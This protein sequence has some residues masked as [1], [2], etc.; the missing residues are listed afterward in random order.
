MVTMT[1]TSAMTNVKFGVPLLLGVI[2][3][4]VAAFIVQQ[5]QQQQKQPF[6]S[7]S[8]STSRRLLLPQTGLHAKTTTKLGETD[9]PQN[10]KKIHL[11]VLVHGWL[12][13]PNELGYLQEELQRQSSSSSSS[14]PDSSSTAMTVVHAAEC[15]DGRTSDGIVPGGKR[16]AVEINSLVEQLSIEYNSY[17]HQ[18]YQPP[19]PKQQQ[20][21]Q[22]NDSKVSTYSQ[23]RSSN[24]VS[25]RGSDGYKLDITISLVGNSLGGLYARY[26]VKDIAWGLQQQRQQQNPSLSSMAVVV[27]PGQFVTTC[28]P[29]LGVNKHTY[30]RIP[31]FAEEIIGRVL[32]QTGKD[33]FQIVDQVDS[34]TKTTS[35]SSTTT[36][37]SSIIHD[38]TTKD[39][40]LTPLSNF[41]RRVA[42]ANAY[43][44]DFQVPTSTA[45]FW[46][47]NDST[48]ADADASSP[49]SLHY[50]VSID[51][52]NYHDTS[53]SEFIPFNPLQPQVQGPQ[54]PSEVVMILRT[55]PSASSSSSSSSKS[56]SENTA[57]L[58]EKLNSLGWTKIVCDV[59]RHIVT[60][61][62]RSLPFFAKTPK[63]KTEQSS[64]DPRT[65]TAKELLSLFDT[66]YGKNIP[67]GHTIAVANSKDTLNR[68]ITKGGR[69]IMD[70]LAKDI[71]TFFD[72]TEQQQLSQQK[73]HQMKDGQAQP[74]FVTFNGN[75]NSKKIKG[76]NSFRQD[77]VLMAKR[78]DN[79]EDQEEESTNVFGRVLA[80]FTNSPGGMILFPFVV[81]FGLDILLNTF[82][83]TKRTFEFF[84]LGQ[85]PSTDTWF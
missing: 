77:T 69:P 40:Y 29:H 41:Q 15:N 13:S 52:Q 51:N 82:F 71:L 58:S 27:K 53:A 67:L 65:F 26:A 85:A 48:N 42:F 34:T 70:Y 2:I 33:L 75:V 57:R 63:T 46:E 31:R 36:S 10:Q 80:P 39:E 74:G 11:I 32:G 62:V 68:W 16:L 54:P 4:M 12:G 79:G 17:H 83:L 59:R 66:E 5:Q 38:M 21:Q 55:K 1:V 24:G 76:S 30:I 9:T 61:R 60:N 28:T 14:L 47:V 20:Q 64:S 43:G 72:K 45:A 18:Q 56:E 84:V 35:S 81:I 3:T 73:V 7:R 37:S 78:G 22:Q 8:S 23:E 49:L 25:S 50:E 44:T 6:S 19:P